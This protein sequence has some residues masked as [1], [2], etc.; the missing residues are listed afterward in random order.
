MWSQSDGTKESTFTQILW[1][2]STSTTC[3]IRIP[4]GLMTWYVES[5]DF[6][7]NF[8]FAS[9]TLFACM[10]VN[11]ILNTVD[12]QKHG[13]NEDILS[14]AQCPPNLL[15][16]SGYD[17][18]V[19]VWNMVSGHIFCHL[20]APIPRE[21]EDQSCMS[22]FF[23]FNFLWIYQYM[24][25]EIIDLWKLYKSYCFMKWK[26]HGTWHL[27]LYITWQCLK[28]INIALISS[29]RYSISSDISVQWMEM[30]SIC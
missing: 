14:V 4:T 3:S 17:G 7:W 10:I 5:L 21:Y 6:F 15:A 11:Y 1:R 16:T 19:I 22:I 30:S 24:Y 26:G 23:F 12:L 27:V 8:S 13:H 29:D 20:S 18:E 25:L 2:M 9:S 28:L